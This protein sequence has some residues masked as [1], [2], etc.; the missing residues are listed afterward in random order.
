MEA[1]GGWL[2]ERRLGSWAWRACIAAGAAARCAVD[3]TC[4]GTRRRRRPT[5]P[6]WERRRPAPPGACG[7]WL[8]ARS[9]HLASTHDNASSTLRPPA[10]R[11]QWRRNY[12]DRG[13][14]H[15]TLQVQ[16]LYPLYPPSQRCGLC[17]NFKQ[18]TL[19]TRLYKDRTN[20]YP[21]LTKTFRSACPPLTEVN[22]TD[23]ILLPHRMIFNKKN[24]SQWVKG[25]RR[26][27]Q[28]EIRLFCK[29][30]LFLFIQPR[31]QLRRTYFFNHYNV[32]FC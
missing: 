2:P 17:Q 20:L 8:N 4:G 19:T 22:W 24:A 28:E 6:R 13:G 10:P 25:S 3:A 14:V 7:N 12:G 31:W 16:D 15:C 11:L 30:N 21:P 29:Q 18:T 27:S 9:P 5:P 23:A 32:L 26:K 1:D